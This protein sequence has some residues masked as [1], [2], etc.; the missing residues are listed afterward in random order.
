MR[1]STV[2]SVV[3]GFLMA[4]SAPLVVRLFNVSEDVG[5]STL[6]MLYTVA[7]IFIVRFLG[8]VIIVGILRGAGDAKS[9][10]A[11]EGATMWLIGVPLTIIGAFY[12][13]FRFI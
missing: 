11:I 1:V 9:A 2:V 4:L 12:L 3:L 7:V 10:L 5:H 8:L 6:L 13:S